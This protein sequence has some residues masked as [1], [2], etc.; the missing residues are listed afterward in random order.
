[1]NAILYLVRV[2]CQWRNLPK[3]FPAWS[4]VNY[5]F[6]QWKKDETFAKINE[7][8]NSL[9]R[10]RQGKEATPSLL[11]IDS[12]SIKLSPSICEDRGFDGNKKING[13]KRQY[14]VDTDG[15]LWGCIVHAAD[16]YDGQ[17]AL[18]LVEQ[19]ARFGPRVKKILVDNHYKGDFADKVIA[20]GLDFEV[21]SRPPTEKG[22]IPIAK[23]WVVERSISWSNYFRRLIKD[24][25]Y[26]ILSSATWM[27]IANLSVMLARFDRFAE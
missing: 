27:I 25:E 7:C 14:V 8:L 10:E 17:G 21:A 22:F 23:R 15:R 16:V 4:A 1:M 26:T 3:Q 11:C 20:A 18:P 5:Y 19:L 13:R 24:H 9:D 2:G 6:E 12:Q